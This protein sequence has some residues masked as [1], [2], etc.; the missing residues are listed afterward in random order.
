M[1]D[2]LETDG[3]SSRPGWK[4]PAF[5]AA[6]VAVLAA[7]TAL[8]IAAFALGN[9]MPALIGA[10]LILDMVVVGGGIGVA[11]RQAL[12]AEKQIDRAQ[13]ISA[14]AR[15]A[16]EE[17][18]ARLGAIVD[19]AMDGIITVDESQR[20]VL[21]NR[22]AEQMFRCTRE[23]ALGASLDRFIPSRFRAA[24][25]GHIEHFGRTGVTNRRMGEAN[26]LWALRADGEEFLIDASISQVTVDGRKLY[27]VILRDITEQLAAEEALRR[28]FNELRKLSAAMHEVREAERTRIARELHDE[29]AQWLTALKM[30]V[31]WLASRLPRDQAPLLE[32]TEK[33]KGVVDTTVTA[34]RRIAADLRPVMLDDL[35]LIPAI[36][37]LL[38]DLSERSGMLNIA[39]EGKLLIGAFTASLTSSLIFIATGNVL[40]ATLAGITAAMLAAGLTEFQYEASQDLPADF[41]LV[42]SG[43]RAIEREALMTTAEMKKGLGNLATI[44]TT[45]PFIGLFG[46]VIGIITAFQGM[47]LTGSGGLGAVSAGI[48]EALG[49]TA[50]GLF[51]AVPAVWMYNYFLNKI[52]RFNVEMSNSSSQ[53][54]DFFIKNEA[55][56]RARA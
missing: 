42:D 26:A 9:D 20:I 45:A 19:S 47:A 23:Q 53:L 14:Q 6:G 1:S 30:D 11:V 55:R 32:R 18:E 3:N 8:N 44:S 2:P 38:H 17:S 31:S 33:M 10:S 29:L 48:A 36:E 27:T 43:K 37:G 54:I 16:L 41:D 34:V 40:L 49:A 56:A 5:I 21:F 28:S 50:L 51:V 39:L 22:A 35:G 46:T 7:V 15:L 12:R 4:R 52:D 25:R 13:Q 24:H